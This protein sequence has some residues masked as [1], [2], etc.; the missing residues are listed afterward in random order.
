M[1][2]DAK[3]NATVLVDNI[4]SG[5]LESEW[6]LS[7][8]IEYNGKKY[9]LDT[10]GSS[11]YLENASKIGIDLSDVDCAFL[12]HAH[13]DHSSGFDSFFKTN[14]HADLFVSDACSCNCYFKLGFV[15]KYV[16]ISEEVFKAN[17]SRIRYV[18]GMQQID[19]GV[20]IVPHIKNNLEKIGKKAHMYRKVNGKIV[21]DDF[22]HEIS[23]VFETSEGLVVLNSCSHGGVPNILKDVEYYL[24]GKKIYMTIGGLHLASMSNGYVKEVAK[25]IHAL[26]IEHIVTGHCTGDRAYKIMKNELG[27]KLQQMYCG[28]KISV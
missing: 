16:G 9:L 22:S 3:F 18:S 17:S 15:R 21:P 6:G 20:Y 10:G 24:P 12:S 14:I 7:I 1:S 27:D 26:S 2:G 5:D 19:D 13:Y 4:P 8:L 25:K 28:L 11:K 23:I